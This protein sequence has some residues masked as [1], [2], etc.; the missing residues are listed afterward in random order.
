MIYK[1]KYYRTSQDDNNKREVEEMEITKHQLKRLKIIPWINVIHVK[2][3]HNVV[4]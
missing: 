2:K 4:V 3:I 1:V